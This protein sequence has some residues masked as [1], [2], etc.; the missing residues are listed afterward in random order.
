MAQPSLDLHAQRR[1]WK[2]WAWPCCSEDDG[3]GTLPGSRGQQ[4]MRQRGGHIAWRVDNLGL[5][6]VWWKEEAAQ[7]REEGAKR[8]GVRGRE[9]QHRFLF[10]DF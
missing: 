2:L 5:T 8:G 9:G 4:R 1:V 7:T 10:L 3:G 6:R